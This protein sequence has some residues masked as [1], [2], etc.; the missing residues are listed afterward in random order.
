MQDVSVVDAVAQIEA[1][2]ILLDV[3]EDYE[4]A[5]GHAPDA[6]HIPMSA[7]SGRTSE[8]PVDRTIV[9]VCH[10]GARSA[11]VADALNR[12]GWTAVNLAGGMEAW[13][14]AGRPVVP[15]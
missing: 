2:A 11:A 1:G 12:S 4:W 5:E 7:L 9:C 8:I 6:V 14:A 3:R 15:G 10:M 13:V